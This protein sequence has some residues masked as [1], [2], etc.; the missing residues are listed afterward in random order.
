MLPVSDEICI[1]DSKSDS[2]PPKSNAKFTTLVFGQDHQH[3]YQPILNLKTHETLKCSQHDI[4]S[5][6]HKGVYVWT[7]TGDVIFDKIESFYC[8]LATVAVYVEI[9]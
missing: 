5:D 8:L 7:L 6:G 2:N 4:K 1:E 9:S 3:K